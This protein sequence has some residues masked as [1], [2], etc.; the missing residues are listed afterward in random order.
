MLTK[1]RQHFT[2]LNS[3]QTFKKSLKSS[4]SRV[5]LYNCPSLKMICTDSLGSSI[6]V[7]GVFFF[8]HLEDLS[9]W[10]KGIQRRG[11]AEGKARESERYDI[12]QTEIGC[13]V[14]SC[15]SAPDLINSCQWERRKLT[16]SHT[17][18]WGRNVET[19]EK[20]LKTSSWL[21]SSGTHG[22]TDLP[23]FLFSTAQK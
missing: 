4:K 14:I 13:C 12:I 1:R 10:V 22:H 20:S 11:V 7:W 21:S 9:A 18:Q 6:S 3:P 8:L 15:F 23:I 5:S 2:K 19:N 17:S 16:H